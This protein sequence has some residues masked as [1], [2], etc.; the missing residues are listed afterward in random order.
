M[1]G[2]VQEEQA[3]ELQAAM[4]EYQVYDSLTEKL[5]RVR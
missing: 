3:Q 4:E 2:Y 1:I 5:F